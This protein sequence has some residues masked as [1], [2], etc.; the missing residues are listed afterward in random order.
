[1]RPKA[2]LACPAGITSRTTRDASLPLQSLGSMG[3][4]SGY[5]SQALI[6]P[7][8]PKHKITSGTLQRLMEMPRVVFGAHLPS[9]QQKHLRGAQVSPPKGKG[10]QHLPSRSGQRQAIAHHPSHPGEKSYLSIFPT[11]F[12]Y[13]A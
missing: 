9:T 5:S 6:P 8:H 3:W 7:P 13:F 4:L 10:T 12:C 1:M 11:D 2:V